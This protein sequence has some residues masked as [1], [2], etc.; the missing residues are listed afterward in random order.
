MRT[1]LRSA[2]LVAV[3]A[4]VGTATSALAGSGV[5]GIFNLG[6]TNSVNAPSSLV[7]S[8][9]GS[10]LVVANLGT[11]ASAKGLAVL[12]RSPSGPAAV[13][14]NTN[15]GPA[16]SLL[17]NSG[18]PPLAVNSTTKVAGLNADLL[19][20]V[21]SA[22]FARGNVSAGS[23]RALLPNGGGQTLLAGSDFGALYASC[24]DHAEIDY[25]NPTPTA[26]ELQTAGISPLGSGVNSFKVPASSS[27]FGLHLSVHPLESIYQRWQFTPASGSSTTQTAVVSMAISWDGSNCVFQ[28]TKESFH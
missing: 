1:F 5:H 26:Y 23:A 21:D 15:G 22:S 27:S 28:A 18:K 8:T 6:E 25:S 20:G 16:L 14:A 24:G 2:A 11:A 4:V 12:G 3:G 10:Q 9:G 13:L 17:V 19:D 7:G